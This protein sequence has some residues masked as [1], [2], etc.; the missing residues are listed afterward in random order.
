MGSLTVAQAKRPVLVLM[1]VDLAT[2]LLLDPLSIKCRSGVDTTEESAQAP[3]SGHRASIGSSATPP[4][5]IESPW[6]GWRFPWGDGSRWGIT[7]RCLAISSTS[8]RPW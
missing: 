5:T 8:L 4:S 6:N 1:R 7:Q 2:P 3:S